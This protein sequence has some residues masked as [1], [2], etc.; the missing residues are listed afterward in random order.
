MLKITPTNA[1]AKARH[2]SPRSLVSV[3][4][5]DCSMG[6]S[7]LRCYHTVRDLQTLSLGS[8]FMLAYPHRLPR[9]IPHGLTLYLLPL[10]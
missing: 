1:V 3:E 4:E 10:I 2:I 9:G 7:V 5:L 6:G 8:V